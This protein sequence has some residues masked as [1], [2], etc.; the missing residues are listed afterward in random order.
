M[1][2]WVNASSFCGAP[3]LLGRSFSK[4]VWWWL[5]ADRRW[6]P[7]DDC[8]LSATGGAVRCGVGWRP[9]ATCG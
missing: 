9:I 2:S 5:P 6:S 3:E 4:E 7:A 1:A 8:G